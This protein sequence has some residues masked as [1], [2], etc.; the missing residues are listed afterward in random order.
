MIAP[1]SANEVYNR[2]RRA[3]EIGVKGGVLH[4]LAAALDK[5]DAQAGRIGAYESRR[6][7][8]Q[9]KVRTIAGVE[10]KALSK[11]PYPSSQMIAEELCLR[12]DA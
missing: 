10:R 11:Q 2:A 4:L 1:V 9:R 6:E 12:A 3:G 8:S 5:G 7:F